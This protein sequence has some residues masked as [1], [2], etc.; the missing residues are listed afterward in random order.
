MS[1]SEEYPPFPP[2]GPPFIPASFHQNTDDGDTTGYVFNHVALQISSPALSF[3]FYVGF[4][5][6]SLIFAINAGPMTAYYLGYRNAEHDAVPSD[7]ARGSGARSGLLELIVANDEDATHGDLTPNGT[8]KLRAS[9][10]GTQSGRR[11]GF[12]HFGF[13]VPNVAETVKRAE[14]KGWKVVKPLD[15]VDVQYMP[16]PGWENE[17]EGKERKWEGGFEKTFAQVAFVQDPDG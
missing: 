17:I 9:G 11:V 13:R 16:L 7:M 15:K 5:G 14:E 4:L 3:S 12:A 10:G 2:P 8:E 1:D 6:M